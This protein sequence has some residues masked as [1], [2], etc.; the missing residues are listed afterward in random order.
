MADKQHYYGWASNEQG[1]SMD[2][3]HGTSIREI[4]N[5]AR[6]TMGSGWTIHVM[7][8]EVNGEQTEVKKFTIR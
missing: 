5:K 1:A 4:E 6:R 8:V 2:V 3:A 7:K